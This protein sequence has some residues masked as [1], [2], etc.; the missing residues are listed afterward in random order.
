MRFVYRKGALKRSL[1]FEVY[2]KLLGYT[3]AHPECTSG[4]SIEAHHIRPL[5][6]GGVDKFWNIICLCWS[7]HHTKKLHSRSEEKLVELYA[8]KSM[9]ELNRLNF[10]FDEEDP[11][12]FN[13]YRDAI[14]NANF[15]E[16]EKLIAFNLDKLTDPR[17][18]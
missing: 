2:K 4:L 15:A 11:E 5:Y 10:M 6:K 17:R 3:C 14:R 16:D 7:C 8:F 1:H 12:F 9:H 18:N 13:R